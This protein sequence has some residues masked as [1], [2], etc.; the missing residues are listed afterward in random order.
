M[1]SCLRRNS[2]R[3]LAAEGDDDLFVTFDLAK[4]TT[5]EIDHL[6]DLP[7]DYVDT[8]WFNEDEYRQM[9]EEMKPTI[10]KMVKGLV[11]EET[12]EVTTRGLGE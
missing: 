6:D 5:L 10:Q 9:K 7:E 4:S 12:D 11:V 3:S 2:S 1:K 8:V